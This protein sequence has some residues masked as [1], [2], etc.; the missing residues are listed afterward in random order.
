MYD[1]TTYAYKIETVK[2]I[3]S[4]DDSIGLLLNSSKVEW[5]VFT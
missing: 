5:L 1:Q 3:R 4:F 2:N